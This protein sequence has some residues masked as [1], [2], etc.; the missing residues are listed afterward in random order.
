MR[1]LFVDLARDLR[2]T[3]RAKRQGRIREI[4]LAWSD[5]ELDNF[6]VFARGLQPAEMAD[7]CYAL[8]DS[9]A[10]PLMELLADYAE[11]H[12]DLRKIAFQSLAKTPVSAKIYIS[13]RLMASTNP[14]VRVG[15]CEMLSSIGV[16]GIER[17]TVAL[18]DP[19][20]TVVAA[21]MRGVVKIGGKKA[22]ATIAAMIATGSPDIKAQ[23]LNAM[24]SL[25]I[26]G[27]VFETQA[28]GV[29]QDSKATTDLRKT[30]AR[31]LAAGASRPGRDVFM[32]VAISEGDLEIR[33]AAAEALGSYH[34]PEVVRTLLDLATQDIQPLVVTASQAMSHIKTEVRLDVLPRRLA[35]KQERLAVAAAEFLGEMPQTAAGEALAR[36]LQE[37]TRP[38][39]VAAIADSLG[40]SV[41]PLAWKAIREKLQD[42][43]ND[44]LP[45]LSALADATP[46][47]KIDDLASLVGTFAGV[48][49]NSFLLFRLAAF[50]R[51]GKTSHLAEDK[52]LAVINSGDNQLVPPAI[53][54][55]AL[56][57]REQLRTQVLPDI[58]RHITKLPIRRIIKSLL[59]IS[60]GELAP[61]FSKVGKETSPLLPVA[62]AEGEVLG[63]GGD[64]FL[65]KVASWVR[66][67]SPGARQGLK[68]AAILD[69]SQ[70]RLAMNISPDKAILLETWAEMDDKDRVQ[71][72]PEWGSIFDNCSDADK[73][74][75][76]KVI[77]KTKEVR[78][79]RS[80]A[81]LAFLEPDGPVRDM[82]VKLTSE[83]LA[84][85]L[86]APDS[87]RALPVLP[88]APPTFAPDSPPPAAQKVA[89]PTG[90]AGP[91]SAAGATPPRVATQPARA[92]SPPA[93]VAPGR[94]VAAVS[95]SPRPSAPLPSA[96]GQSPPGQAVYPQVAPQ[97]ARAF[98]PPAAV[99]PGRPVAAS[100]P[101]RPSAPLPPAPGQPHPGQVV[102]P[103]VATQPPRAGSPPAAVAPGRPAAAVSPSPVPRAPLPPAPGQPPP[104]QV[105]SPRVATQPAR[106][107]S[108]PAAV[109]PG[110][111]VA[112]VSPR[113]AVS[114]SPGPRAPLPPAPG[115][116]LPG[117]G[118][119]PRMASS[120][121]AHPGSGVPLAPVSQPGRTVSA[122]AKA[123]VIVQARRGVEPA[124]AGVGQVFKDGTVASEPAGPVKA[125]T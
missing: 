57:D 3:V 79:L 23:A 13:T 69:P 100:Q 50:A 26:S 102:S 51:A 34:D 18:S 14:E 45:L 119:S 103:R 55:L 71:N 46:A 64:V 83:I 29:F 76:M 85:G 117:H 58:A 20:A 109:A 43:R 98:S 91:A 96:P 107:V 73:L 39:V 74:T 70:L 93:A 121:P 37:E 113:A 4:E 80:V 7:I 123:G 10:L 36:F 72:I 101:P 44:P 47:E 110:R 87:M 12:D 22:A 78:P 77:R 61:L 65:S 9:T 30:A 19:D 108:P 25:G 21:A 86:K 90:V 49:E 63:P 5:N 33:R 106:A 53:E 68:L 54:I 105:V 89:Q 62:A 120:A 60:D 99:A 6:R 2:D 28:L 81:M 17:L 16:S 94:P 38:V 32:K 31:A 88:P 11:M 48:R 92:G 41:Y 111:P 97:P 1:G 27:P 42:S 84:I 56:S 24:I 114:P 75:I 35:D 112:A 125:K 8:S 124:V 122:P 52:A 59:K 67:D 66:A 95:P 15:A 115:Q 104:G 118:V 40:R 82:A 116:A